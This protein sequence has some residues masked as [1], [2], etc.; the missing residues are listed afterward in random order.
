[1]PFTF[2][3]GCS[4]STRYTI[5]T[6]IPTEI[7]LNETAIRVLIDEDETST[8]LTLQTPVYLYNGTKKLALI[9]PG[10]TIECYNTSDEITVKI[11]SKKFT[12]SYFHLQPADN[13]HI[14]FNG[15]SYK[16]S[17]KTYGNR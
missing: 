13:S 11:N 2:F 12:D 3:T 9:N 5:E 8:F 4:S 17:I 14:N 7:G 1:M 15:K 10:N 16:G 6:E